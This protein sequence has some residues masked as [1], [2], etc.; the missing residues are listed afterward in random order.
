MRDKHTHLRLTWM[1]MVLLALP[2]SLVTKQVTSNPWMLSLMG[3]KGKSS[4]FTE[5]SLAR[6]CPA[7]DTHSILSATPKSLEH[8]STAEFPTIKPAVSLVMVTP[9]VWMRN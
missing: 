8:V 9:I 6:T 4:C 7:P 5:V 2:S 1:V 3:L